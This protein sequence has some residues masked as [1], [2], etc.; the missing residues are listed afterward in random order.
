MAVKHRRPP[1][2]LLHHLDRGSQ[3]TSEV[4]L[5]SL[6]K[7]GCRVS[8]SRVGNCYD[9]AVMESLYATLKG[10]CVYRR[11]ATKAKARLTIFEYIEVWYNRQRLHSSLVYFGLIEFE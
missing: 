2:Q 1:I 9:N 10:E 11:F 7:A 3:Y 6:E 5:K 4:Y 8:L